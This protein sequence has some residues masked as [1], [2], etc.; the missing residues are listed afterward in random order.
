[1]KLSLL[2]FLTSI[3]Q[4]FSLNTQDQCSMVTN[5]APC[6]QQ[7]DT[8]EVCL[9]KGCCYNP[10]FKNI[11]CFYGGGNAVPITTVH[12]IQACHFDSGFADSSVNILNLW[13]NHHFP[14]AYQIGLELDALNGPERL[15]FMAQ[16]YIV[17]LYTDCPPNAGLAC[18]SPEQLQNF[19]DAVNKGY[20]T[21]HS[22][23]FNGEFELTDATMVNLGFAMTHAL[24]DTFSLPRKAT[25][26]QRDVP[27][28][29]R[30]V[31]PLLKANGIETITVGVNGASTP[32][33]V[34]R[35]FIWKDENTNSSIFSM[36]HPYGY[37]G[38]AFEDAVQL[39][40]FE[41][42]VVFDWRGD[43]AGPPTSVSEVQG[44]WKTIQQAFPG[45]QI[46][47]S[48]LD[49]YT[50]IV[51]SRPDVLALLPV[52]TSE[53]GDTWLH[54]S[55]SDPQKNAKFKVAQHVIR[56]CLE[57]NNCDPTS[58]NFRNFTR[59]IVKNQEHTWGRDIKT[60]LHDTTNWTNTDLQ[61]ALAQNYSN[62][63]TVLQS[64]YEQRAFGFTYPL[65]ALPDGDYLKQALLTA[66]E[67]LVPPAYPPNPV[68]NG[69]TKANAGQNY[70]VGRYT[71]TFDP[72]TG[73]IS[74]LSDSTTGATWAAASTDGSSLGVLEYLTYDQTDYNLFF[75]NYCAVQPAPGWFLLD[76]GKPNMTVA[77]PVH[78]EIKQ[79]LTSLW[80]ITDAAA[81]VVSFLVSAVIGDGSQ[82][83]NYGA[84]SSVWLQY[85][86]PSTNTDNTIN[87]T[88]SIYNKTAT[89]LPEALYIHFNASGSGSPSGLPAWYAD[90]LEQW[91]NPFDVVMGGNKYHHG[92]GRRG[93]MATKPGPNNN[94]VTLMIGT[95]DASIASFGHIRGLPTP[96]TTDAEPSEGGSFMLIN[97]M[98]GT[99]YPMWIPFDN[100]DAN[101]QWH[102]NLNFF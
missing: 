73:G 59:L 5:P 23:P 40:N 102:F 27:G 67:S 33:K 49:N 77:N 19:T 98:W 18:P 4:I 74:A 100:N 85:D 11:P 80:T 84:P 53:I 64:W 2:L 56:D 44:D 25:V 9:A 14:L 31:I 97:N 72:V 68:V 41:H 45:A 8:E 65:Q 38:I 92:V 71:I 43:N 32:P 36:W 3:T 79:S 16:S 47:A 10:N 87:I 61:H 66:W 101:M 51:N 62:F 90:K 12:V 37:G 15:R 54:G 13:F 69:W 91:V 1:M 95:P 99:N 88:L 28:M 39:P 24:D 6:G 89:R 58:Y 75:G 20:I 30:S 93:I 42:A 21:W 26:S 7:S 52:I 48:T 57:S 63:Y 55:V 50:S 29:T 94:N 46:V 70:K 86:I 81:N 60:Y 17:S 82:H 35:G 83:T 78:Q 22:W 76:F 34:P 96:T